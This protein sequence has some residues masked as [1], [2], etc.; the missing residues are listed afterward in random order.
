MTVRRCDAKD[1]AKI[2][3]EDPLGAA[4][5]DLAFAAQNE[6]RADYLVAWIGGQPV[7]SGQLE[8]TQP[9]ELKSLHVEP[10]HRGA[11]IGTAIIR[12]AEQLSRGHGTLIVGVGQDNP[13]ARRLY[14]RLG[15]VATGRLETYTY[16]YVD[17]AGVS[18]DATETAEYLE[19]ALRRV[20]G[21]D[22][23]AQTVSASIGG[24]SATT[25]STCGASS[26]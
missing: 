24:K 25:S 21:N 11:G 20:R 4:Y 15:Y 12:H 19:K 7:G 23:L 17:T 3:A 10:E 8:W 16:S 9:P 5:A 14:E 13:D 18:R 6:E 2:V 1:L 26:R 22:A